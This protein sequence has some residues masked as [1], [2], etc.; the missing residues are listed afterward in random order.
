MCC[1]RETPFAVRYRDTTSPVLKA[2]AWLVV[3]YLLGLATGALAAR[4]ILVRV[5][6]SPSAP[7]TAD[8][9][10]AH[11]VETL[12][13]EVN[14][15]DV[16]KQN[17]NAILLDVSLE[18]SAINRETDARKRELRAQGEDQIRG[19]LTP[20]QRPKF[21]QWLRRLD[22]QRQQKKIRQR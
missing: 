3:V 1:G 8:A 10:R 5:D 4:Q 12:A 22:E 11:I 6:A 16:Q 21:D 17:L 19:I 14:L 2:A 9:R 15:T 20:D 13:R 18:F 7:L